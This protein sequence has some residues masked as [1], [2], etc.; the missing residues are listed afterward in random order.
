MD[1]EP[2]ERDSEATGQRPA[3]SMEAAVSIYQSVD[4][5]PMVERLSAEAPEDLIGTLTERVW[6]LASQAGGGIPREAVHAVVENLVHADFD[7]VVVSILDG[8]NTVRVADRGPGIADKRKALLPG[9]TTATPAAR[10]LLK[11]VGS[12]LAVAQAAMTL[13]GG[14]LELDDNLDGGTVVTLWLPSEQ[15]GLEPDRPELPSHSGVHDRAPAEGPAPPS[16]TRADR[17]DAAG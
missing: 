4:A 13:R 8:G 12:G 14:G 17:A 1:A 3:V 11:G 10:S 16:G 2:A 9:F 6:S 7:Q 5:A 15:A